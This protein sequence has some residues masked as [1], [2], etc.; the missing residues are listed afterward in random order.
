MNETNTNKNALKSHFGV[1]STIAGVIMVASASNMA[2][3]LYSNLDGV[4]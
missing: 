1:H 2:P 4:S 3:T